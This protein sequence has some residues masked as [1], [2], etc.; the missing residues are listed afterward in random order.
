M[1]N[2]FSLAEKNKQSLK[3]KKVQVWTP[4][5]Y[6]KYIR[7]NTKT[8]KKCFHLFFATRYNEKFKIWIFLA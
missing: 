4:S 5:N 1:E 3:S 6:P 8:S 2:C 7:K